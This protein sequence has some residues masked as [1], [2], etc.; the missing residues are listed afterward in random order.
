MSVCLVFDSTHQ[1]FER[2]DVYF[3]FKSSNY[4]LQITQIGFLGHNRI[5][6]RLV[7]F[8]VQS[9]SHALFVGFLINFLFELINPLFYA[10]LQLLNVFGATRH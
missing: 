3:V 4:T 10:E 7:S 5:H 6:L 9:L 1:S 8:P 2:S